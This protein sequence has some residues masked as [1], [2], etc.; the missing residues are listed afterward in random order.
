[1][2]ASTASTK[3]WKEAEKSRTGRIA[4]MLLRKAL[5]KSCL[6]CSNRA[7]AGCLRCST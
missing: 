1:M 5:Q 6:R 2:G 7:D 4:C 3:S